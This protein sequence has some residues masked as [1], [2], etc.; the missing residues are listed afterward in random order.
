MYLALAS[1]EPIYCQ[2]SNGSA[3]EVVDALKKAMIIQNDLEVLMLNLYR[4]AI[5][6]SQVLR[7]SSRWVSIV[8]PMSR[9]VHE[10]K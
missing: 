9:S 4:D 6:T 3:S 5:F 8:N 7:Y 10:Y 2:L 1:A